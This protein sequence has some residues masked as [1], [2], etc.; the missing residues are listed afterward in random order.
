MSVCSFFLVILLITK[1]GMLNVINYDFGFAYL[2]FILGFLIKGNDLRFIFRCIRINAY[3]VFLKNW[4]FCICRVSRYLGWQVLTGLCLVL[5]LRRH[6]S[7]LT[8]G[9]HWSCPTLSL[10][11]QLLYVKSLVGSIRL[12]SCLVYL[13]N[14]CILIGIFDPFTL[15][16]IARLSCLMR[17]SYPEK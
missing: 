8:L 14:L 16:K 7:L 17:L 5:V 1:N 3:C 13:D 11:A 6:G 2:F 10:S 4:Q 15:N 9:A 12:I